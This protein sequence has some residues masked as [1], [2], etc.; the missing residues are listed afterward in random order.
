MN[1]Y[2]Q[3]FTTFF[4]IGAFTIGGGYAMLPLIQHEV[5]EKKGWLSEDE[6]LNCTALSQSSPGPIAVNI[7]VLTGYR[8]G[9][10]A[11]SVCTT[12]GA[13][14]PAIFIMTGVAAL[15]SHFYGQKSLEHVFAGI[16][17]VVTALIASAVIKMGRNFRFRGYFV[18]LVALL[19][20]VVLKISPV[21]VILG[22]IVIGVILHFMR[23]RK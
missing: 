23:G 6:F 18:S 9:R 11:G 21:Y 16:R 3:L 7:A 13:V 15:F 5:V 2:L 19:L 10:F 14:L 12:L 20:V 4:R 1:I 8:T 22:S 17:P